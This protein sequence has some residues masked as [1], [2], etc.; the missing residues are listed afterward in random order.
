[1]YE[2]LRKG[3][4]FMVDYL[5][6]MGAFSELIFTHVYIGFNISD[7][8]GPFDKL[9]PFRMGL[10]KLALLFMAINKNLV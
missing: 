10:M 3:F 4:V 7:P 5:C 9:H 1:M 2:R 6:D 8:P